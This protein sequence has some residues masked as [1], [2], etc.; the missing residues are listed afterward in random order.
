ME[1][2]FPSVSPSA[3]G[4]QHI[5]NSGSFPSKIIDLTSYWN[6]DWTNFF[7]RVMVNS[8]LRP[9]SMSSAYEFRHN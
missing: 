4:V 5:E 8:I 9:I 7:L 6:F 1:R 2:E 3:S